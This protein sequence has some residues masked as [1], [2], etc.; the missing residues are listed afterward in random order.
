M[1]DVPYLPIDPHDVGRSYRTLVRISTQSGKGGIAHL[2]RT[3]H[4][5]DLPQGLRAEFA[6]EVQ[7]VL[8]SRGGTL[9]PEE[10]LELFRERFLAPP[11]PPGVRPRVEVLEV[12]EQAVTHGCAVYC[13]MRAGGATRWGVGLGRRR[14]SA[15]RHALYSGLCRLAAV[16][17]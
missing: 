14:E 17:G 12:V 16:L 3:E 13:R 10:L 4:G 1:W 5:L 7:S 2:M 15:R 9:E 6:E 11:R 8:D